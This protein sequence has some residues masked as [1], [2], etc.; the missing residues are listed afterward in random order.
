MSHCYL[1]LWLPKHIFKY[2][3]LNLWPYGMRQENLCLN[4][5]ILPISVETSQLLDWFS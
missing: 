4:G 1:N 2:S 5:T 3:L